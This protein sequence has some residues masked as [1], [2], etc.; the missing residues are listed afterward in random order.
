MMLL[1]A[2]CATPRVVADNGCAWVKPITL[3]DDE[4]IVFAANIRTMRPLADQIN[5]QNTTRAEKCG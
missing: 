4:F 1:C 2:A 3:T 5:A